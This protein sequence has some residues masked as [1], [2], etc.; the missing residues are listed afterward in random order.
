VRGRKAVDFGC[1]AGR[2]TRFLRTL[3]FDAVG[4]DD[5]HEAYRRAG[6]TPIQTYRP[7]ARPTEA[8]SWVNEATIAPWVI[9]VLGR[10]E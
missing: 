2:S 6:L 7:L 3:G 4:V 9:Y 8:R 1:G 5:Y 10:A